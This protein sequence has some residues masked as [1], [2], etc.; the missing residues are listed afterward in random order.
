MVLVDTLRGDTY[1]VSQALGQGSSGCRADPQGFARASGVLRQ[2]LADAPDLVVCNRF[3]KL[4]A[5]GEGFADE[6][7]AVMAEGLPLLTAVAP[8]YVADW[9]RF[10]GGAPLIEPDERAVDDWLRAA[11]V[12]PGAPYSR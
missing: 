4:E 5:A 2:A 12:L 6:L 8:A 3:G 9:Q 11:P 10:S 1:P 7:L